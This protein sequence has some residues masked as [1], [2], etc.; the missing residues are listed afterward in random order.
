M[1]LCLTIN[2]GV[3]KVMTLPHGQDRF[4]H[5]HYSFILNEFYVLIAWFSLLCF[6][7]LPAQ[8]EYVIY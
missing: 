3:G 4:W 2:A 7:S 5:N 8:A 1:Q 6:Q